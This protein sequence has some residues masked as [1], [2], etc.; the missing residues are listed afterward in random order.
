MQITADG[1]LKQ[2]L[3]EKG[4]HEYVD[5][6][7]EVDDLDYEQHYRRA[8]HQHPKY[9]IERLRA[10]AIYSIIARNAVPK[11]ER[12]SIGEAAAHSVS[13]AGRALEAQS[14]DFRVVAKSFEALDST[15]CHL[16]AQAAA[17]HQEV[18]RLADEQRKATE[19]S[20]DQAKR[21]T[22]AVNAQLSVTN[23]AFIRIATWQQE[24]GDFWRASRPFDWAL[25]LI[26]IAEL[27]YLC[28]RG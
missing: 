8:V 6:P 12:E 9:D 10:W 1:I 5:A 3:E 19:L 23:A 13:R 20:T 17:Q 28:Y 7:F 14:K 2:W 26:I 15:M 22:D 4:Y 16:R 18:V 11:A 25:K 21:L 24:I 27:A